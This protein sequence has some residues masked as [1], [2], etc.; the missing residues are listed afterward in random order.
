METQL[1]T[2]MPAEEYF[3]V[4][5]LSAS[6]IK[7]LS[8]GSLDY[9]HYVYGPGSQQEGTAAMKLG[10][11]KHL[12]GLEGLEAFRKTYI[13]AIDKRD[14]DG[15]LDSQEELKGWCRDHGLAVGGSKAVLCDRITDALDALDGD[16]P[17]LWMNEVE[18]QKNIAAK[19]GQEI[20]PQ[21]DYK[22][23]LS[24]AKQIAPIIDQMRD[25]GGM[26]EVS[27]FWE[28]DGIPCKARL[29]YLAP[30][31]AFDLK[32][33]ANTNRMPFGDLVAKTMANMLMVIQA[34]FYLM[35]ARAAQSAGLLPFEYSGEWVFKW[36][37][38]QSAGTSNMCMRTHIEKQKS[39]D[40]GLIEQT[41]ASLK[42]QKL[43]GQGMHLYKQYMKSH[44]S[45][46]P[47]VPELDDQ[48]MTD[49]MYPFWFLSDMEDDEV[50]L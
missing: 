26:P 24:K 45:D 31:I 48:E 25:A 38:L 46:R 22:D 44:G 16:R 37:F 40:S 42:G 10:T 4:K 23:A 28:Q 29:D 6:G 17:T 41:M 43:I 1:I 20:L 8:S 7:Y 14:Y 35:A 21:D 50:E 39:M 32:N 27:I 34:E 3:A 11:A 13:P 15:V 9:W 2:N 5:A 18:G 47:W 12:A 33:V 49:I 30:G 36:L 19:Q